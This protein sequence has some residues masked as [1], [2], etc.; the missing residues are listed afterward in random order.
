MAVIA[1]ESGAEGVHNFRKVPPG[2]L[3]A[4]KEEAKAVLTLFL[5]KQGLSNAV[6]ARTIN[7]AEQFI[8][9][10]VSKLHSIHKT[11]YLVGLISNMSILLNDNEPIDFFWSDLFIN[12]WSMQEG[13]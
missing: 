11:R 4:E 13:N 2:L 8:E 9:H 1:V 7:K 10:L 5:R 6:A 12:V 3:T